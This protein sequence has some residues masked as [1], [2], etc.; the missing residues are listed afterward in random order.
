MFYF[1]ITLDEM[2][3]LRRVQKCYL[4]VF[5]RSIHRVITCFTNNGVLYS[6]ITLVEMISLCRVE[7]I[8]L[9]ILTGSTNSVPT[10]ILK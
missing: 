4:K 1:K 2:T 5:K 8:Y 3:S 7:E 6:K 9:E 10:Y